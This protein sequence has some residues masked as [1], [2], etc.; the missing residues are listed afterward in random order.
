[1]EAIMQWIKGVIIL[2]ILLKVV[3]YLVADSR[4]YRYIH[5]FS[6]LIIILAILMPLTGMRGTGQLLVEKLRGLELT[7]AL[8]EAQGQ[9]QTID[10]LDKEY[11]DREYDRII[12]ACVEETAGEYGFAVKE[13]DAEVSQEGEVE[14]I[15]M[16]IQEIRQGNDIMISDIVID[17]AGEKSGVYDYIYSDFQKKLSQTYGIAE[18]KILITMKKG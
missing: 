2:F 3:L 9:A 18:D 4:Y 12:G 16:S 14:Q 8:R 13:F 1:M 5:F 17:A 11:Y 7:E 10:F 15:S 6:G